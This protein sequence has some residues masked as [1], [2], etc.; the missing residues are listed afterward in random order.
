M[1]YTTWVYIHIL[2]SNPPDPEYDSP[3]VRHNLISICQKG[4][5]E[6]TARVGH[7]GILI[8]VKAHRISYAA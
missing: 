4:S 6:Y 1:P 3:L 5:A 7:S 2:G 8:S